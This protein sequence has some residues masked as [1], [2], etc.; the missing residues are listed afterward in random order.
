MPIHGGG[1]NVEVASWIWLSEI[2]LLLEC[3]RV[4]RKS[5][6]QPICYILPDMEREWVSTCTH[7]TIMPILSVIHKISAVYQ[8]CRPKNSIYHYIGQ[9]FERIIQQAC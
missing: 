7:F 3:T 9:E 6:Y 5:Q 2:P 8:L 1:G 4:I